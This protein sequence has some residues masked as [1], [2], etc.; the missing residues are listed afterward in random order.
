MHS[1]PQ[2]QD[3]TPPTCLAVQVK[4]SCTADCSRGRWTSFLTVV[5][6]GRAGLAALQV[7]EGRGNLTILQ[8]GGQ[9]EGGDNNDRAELRV[10][11]GQTKLDVPAGVRGQPLTVSYT[12]SCCF[13]QAEL[14]V[15]DRARNM[16]RCHLSASQQ[17]AIMESI[18]AAR[19]TEITLS[20][21][22]LGILWPVL[23]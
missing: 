14:L 20:L 19:R 3:T 6:R 11:H 21:M 8:E 17:G 2:D 9:S 12:S 18:S 22:L 4:A 1:A 5:D 15:W 10:G 7:S 13:P 23:M 16:K